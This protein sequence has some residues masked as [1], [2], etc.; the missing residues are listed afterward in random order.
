MTLDLSKV[1][2]RETLTPL[3]NRKAHWQR[4]RPG[5]F[6]GYRPAAK[7]GAGSWCARAYDEERRGYREK[8]LGS[9]P[10]QIA[11][12]RFAVA[13]LAAEAFAVEVERGDVGDPNVEKIETVEQACRAYAKVNTEAAGRFQRLIYDDPIAK[14]KLAKLRRSTLAAWRQR[15]TDKPALVSRNKG[16]EVK[17]RARAASTVNREICMVRAALNKVI[18]P[19]TP[20]TEAAWQE[21][22]VKTPNADGRRTTYLDKG[23]RRAVLENTSDEALPFFKGLC[24]LPLRPGALAQLTVAEWEPR[25]NTLTI[26]KDKGTDGKVEPRR[27]KLP[28]DVAALLT[29]QATDKLPA[30]PLFMRDNGKAWDKDSWGDAIEAAVKAVNAKADEAKRPADRLP[31]GVSAYTLRHSTI[32]DLVNAGLPLLTIAQIS[33]TSIEMIERHYGHLTG[34]AAVEALA[35]LAL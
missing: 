13:K 33:G 24:L 2:K 9:Y 12:E 19:G 7:G 25:T 15:L 18:A 5:C 17:T 31:A 3:P 23:Q 1:G 10:D 29:E 11:S 14:V 27:V 21:A 8:P 28:A 6:V 35:G 32:T 22:L 26:G 4:L 30:A 34:H 20:N 16:G